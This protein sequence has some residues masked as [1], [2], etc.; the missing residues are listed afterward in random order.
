M[1]YWQDDIRA[2]GQGNKTEI[3][4]DLRSGIK[5]FKSPSEL[6]SNPSLFG[7]N[8]VKAGGVGQGIIGDCWLFAAMAGVAEYPERIKKI[9]VNQDITPSGIYQVKLWFKG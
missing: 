7:K 2:W 8:G 4:T 6:E 3:L 9:F 1:F 5:S